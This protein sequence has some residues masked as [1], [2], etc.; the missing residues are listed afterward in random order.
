MKFS[1]RSWLPVIFLGALGTGV[2]QAPPVAPVFNSHEVGADGSITFR[3]MAPG[4]K[5]V[6]LTFD[7][8]N[9]P[10]PMIAG[11]NGIWSVTTP[12]QP[13][14][15]YGYAFTVDGLYE[16]DPVN[17]DS[18]PNLLLLG[19]NVEV[20][21]ATSQPWDL[22]NIPH[23]RVDYHEYTTHIGKHLPQEQEPYIVYTPAGYDAKKP[24]GYPV[25]YLL[26]GWSDPVRGWDET[27]HASQIIDSEIASGKALPMIVVMPRG[28]GDYDFVTSG[29][30]VWQDP[31]K[32]DNNT[33]LYTQMLESEIMPAVEHEYNVSKARE[34]HGIAGLSMGGLESLSIGLNHPAQFAYVAGFSSAIFPDR[35]DA[36]FPKA[37]PKQAP[38]LLW[39][40]CGT[41]DHLHAPNQAFIK[42]AQGKG[43]AP[44]NIQTPGAHEWPVWRGNLVTLLPLLFR[45]PVTHR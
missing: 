18:R 32:V 23:G 34:M 44:V 43:Y 2:A 19:S 15:I 33:G 27:G 1:L 8:I 31:A 5:V 37:D 20:P 40:A 6:T 3:L 30:G 39:V 24:G 22:Q 14:Q 4:A 9:H 10:L 45:S 11:D 26:H 25:L 36:L 17:R 12:P 38:S 16:Q 35:L 21:G 29:S 41:D 7:N 13:P 42:W 28:Y